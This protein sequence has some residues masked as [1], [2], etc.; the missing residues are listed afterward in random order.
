MGR[1]KNMLRDVA[2]NLSREFTGDSGDNLENILATY[3]APTLQ[4]GT[5]IW[6]SKSLLILS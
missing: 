3:P 5:T 2:V 4:V 6:Q 1:N